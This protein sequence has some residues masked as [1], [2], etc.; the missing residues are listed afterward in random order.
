MRDITSFHKDS[1][2][3]ARD[4]VPSW[5]EQDRVWAVA[6]LKVYIMWSLE[7]KFEKLWVLADSRLQIGVWT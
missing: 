1:Q 5:I 6:S 3:S 4:Q 7:F 2:R